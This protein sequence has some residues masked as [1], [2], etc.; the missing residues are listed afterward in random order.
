MTLRRINSPTTTPFT[1]FRARHIRT[2]CLVSLLTGAA[3]TAC[4]DDDTL[5]G[6]SSTGTPGTGTGTT[7]TGTTG[8]G[9][10]SG[11]GTTGTG[12]TGTGTGATGTGAGAGGTTAAGASSGTGAGTTGTGTTG[13]GTSSGTESSTVGGGV[14]AAGAGGSAGNS[15]A[16]NA[17]GAAGASFDGGVPGDAG[18]A[19]T[20]Q[21]LSDGE[22]VF[23]ADTLN[24]GEVDEARAALPRLGN[25]AVRAFARQMIEEH[26]TARDQLLQLADDQDLTPA[27]SDV[28]EDLRQQS[29]SVIAQLLAPEATSLDALYINSQV[30]AHG[31]A[32]QT[33]D[34][35]IAGS[36]NAALRQQ[37][38]ALRSS[39]EE[40]LSRARELQDSAQ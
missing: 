29:E 33:V 17:A 40:H 11:T 10:S 30:T 34:G 15:G 20:A 25:E 8:T 36:D 5:P 2:L 19:A 21:N 39:V 7:G 27:L 9:T 35:L 38:T 3:V 14:G 12:T 23:A 1:S 16:A 31:L 6:I 18:L 32:L 28:A 13:T 4:G 37:L 22:I 26:Q 24:A